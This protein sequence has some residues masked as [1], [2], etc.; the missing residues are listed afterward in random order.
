[1]VL[2]K[3]QFVGER[4]L[5]GT[6]GVRGKANVYP[7]TCEVAV[8][9]GRAV[10]H[11]FQKSDKMG[12]RTP[13]IIV[14]KDT[15]L[16]CYML[17]LAFSSGVC[18]QG[19]RVVLTGPLPTPGVAFVTRSMRADAGVVISASHN[20]FYDNGIK[21]FDAGGDKLPDEVELEIEKMVLNPKLIP[22]QSGDLLG[23][24]KRLDEVIGRY[25]VFAKSVFNDNHS[26][27]G[28]RVVVDC[29]NGAAY[30]VAPMIFEE[31]GAE[32]VPLGVEPNGQNIN[33]NCGALHPDICARSVLKYRAN[34]GICLDGDSDRLIII[35]SQGEIVD[36][37]KIIALLA[38][39]FLETGEMKK[40]D[41]VVGTVMSN[42]GL[43]KYV[44]SLGLKFYRS[45]V[46][47]RYIASRMKESG[48][49]LGGE[50]S[51]HIILRK[52]TTTGDGII[53]ALKT[54]ECTKYYKR[55]LDELVDEIKLFPQVLKNVKVAKTTPLHE[56]PRLS[57]EMALME[58]KLGDGGR[59]LLRYSGTEAVLR[60]MAEGEDHGLVE[61]VVNHLVRVVEE[62][63]C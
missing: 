27:N 2:F 22:N 34:V 62:E 33:M 19:W 14:G 4:K 12:G 41:E 37:D 16:S 10:T 63:L 31:L 44:K 36:G 23:R 3:E 26:L 52:Y 6:D 8:A 40:G 5:F 60:V 45:S 17:E 49:V 32:V 38:K 35:D 13:L 47:D 20:P 29:A 30:K 57:K 53:A 21:I 15:R 42:F 61:E 1:V 48:S 24:A 50:P 39:Y 28:E 46:G 9:L 7:M 43:E 54:L 56:V 59:I 51:G 25:I 11:Y 58:K 55:S 18:S